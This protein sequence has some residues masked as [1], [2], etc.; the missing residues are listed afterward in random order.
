MIVRTKL[1][2]P[3]S[4][5]ALVFAFAAPAFA[6]DM[7]KG[8]GK[9]GGQ[10]GMSQPSDSKMSSPTNKG[11]MSQTPSSGTGG[12]SKDNMGNQNSGSGSGGMSK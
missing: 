6:D 7:G 11:N 12:M 10:S 2:L 9:D 5:L 1:L 3:L 4:A 8:M